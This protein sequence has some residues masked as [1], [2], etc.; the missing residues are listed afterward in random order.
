VVALARHSRKDLTAGADTEAL[1]GRLT[2]AAEEFVALSRREAQERPGEDA[3]RAREVE[4]Q[5]RALL[6]AFGLR[7]DHERLSPELVYAVFREQ[8][9]EDELAGRHLTA[10]L[11]HLNVRWFDED[12][13]HMPRPS[14]QEAFRAAVEGVRLIARRMELAAL[15]YAAKAAAAGKREAPWPELRLFSDLCAIY[16]TA[17]G[18]PPSYSAKRTTPSA[19][20]QPSDSAGR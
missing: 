14:G 6:G 19:T 12:P 9:A 1:A 13:A 8:P 2:L 16:T 7:D 17:F 20:Y 4:R 5:A 11:Y 18:T 3:K 15:A 10:M